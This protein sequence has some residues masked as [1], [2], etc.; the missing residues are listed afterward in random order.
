MQLPVD[1]VS[2]GERGVLLLY[3]HLRLLQ[4][5]RAPLSCSVSVPSMAGPPDE[6][7]ACEARP[8]GPRLGI[9]MGTKAHP[10]TLTDSSPDT[11]A[12]PL[13]WDREG[14]PTQGLRS[15]YPR[16]GGHGG[17]PG[18]D[19]RAGLGWADTREQGGGGQ[20]VPTAELSR[21]QTRQQGAFGQVSLGGDEEAGGL[22]VHVVALQGEGPCECAGGH[23]PTVLLPSRAPRVGG[24]LPC[25][26]WRTARRTWGA[27]CQTS[28]RQC[29]R[30]RRPRR[31]GGCLHPPHTAEQR[32]WPQRGTG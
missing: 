5:P 12:V 18:E 7:A 24:T 6:R 14:S 16:E 21:R 32:G 28:S 25:R 1:K 17:K 26:H 4:S 15:W 30:W 22:P 11:T 20:P 31:S 13:S 3:P 23:L 29:H 19:G 8:R 27:C 10:A 2:A 9:G